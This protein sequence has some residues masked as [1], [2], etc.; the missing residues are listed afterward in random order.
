MIGASRPIGERRV[1]S[2]R[3]PDEISRENRA[4]LRRERI[5]M[6]LEG[7]L[8]RVERGGPAGLTDGE[9]RE[10]GRLYRATSSNLA[11]ARS[12]GASTRRIDYLNRLVTRGHGALY[13]RAQRGSAWRTVLWSPLVFPEVIRRTW[14]FHLAAILLF[15]AGGVYG[16]VGAIGDPEWSLEFMPPE[17]ARTAFA[18]RDQLLASLLYGRPGL[19]REMREGEKAIFASFLWQHNTR[20]GLLAFFGGFLAGVPTVLLELFNGLH[21][22]VYSAAFHRHDLQWE[23]WAWLLPHGV[24]EILAIILL[25]GGGLLIGYRVI[26]PGNLSRIEALKEV[27]GQ[28]LHILLYAFPMF[29]I[30]AAIESWLRQSGMSEVGR[31]LLVKVPESMRF[32]QAGKT[33]AEE[34]VPAPTEEELLAGLGLFRGPP[35]SRRSSRDRI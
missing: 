12:F 21:L 13:G 27:R 15:L 14:P 34:W 5:W 17:E 20:V 16:Y 7:L 26:V 24:T 22:G 29:L 1:S 10:L 30:A 4:E 18:T 35:A 6:R 11:Q 19:P 33:V 32:S 3:E 31:Y 9:L 23:W 28:A 25:S 8:D 2:L